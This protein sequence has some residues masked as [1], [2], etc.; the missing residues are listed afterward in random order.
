M[1]DEGRCPDGGDALAKENPLMK[2]EWLMKED[3]LMVKT[4]W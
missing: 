3:V 1:S 2:G 4:P